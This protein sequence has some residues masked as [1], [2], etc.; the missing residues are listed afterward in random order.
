MSQ[1]I[2][3]WLHLK[4]LKTH[5]SEIISSSSTNQLKTL[6][7]EIKFPV[8]F[9]LI[10]TQQSLSSPQNIQAQIKRS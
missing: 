7:M 4:S 2:T 5:A 1:M 6:I 9:L 10:M 8:K 3:L